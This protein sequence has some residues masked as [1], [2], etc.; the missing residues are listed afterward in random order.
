M[1]DRKKFI[2]L[3][4]A[5]IAAYLIPF[6]HPRV[7]VAILEAFFMLKEYAHEHL[8]L[9]LVPAFFIAGGITVF[10][11]QASVIKYFGAEAKKVLAYGMASVSGSILAVCSCTVLPLFTGIYQRGA[12]IGPA[13]AFLYSGP[14]INVLAIILTARVLGLK[15]GLARALGAILFS[16]V[17]GLL[18]AFIYRQQDKERLTVPG[19]ETM[20]IEKSRKLWQEL[21]YFSLM[22]AFLVFA[23]WSN[24]AEPDGLWSAIYNVKWYLSALFL[25]LLVPVLWLWFKKD[26]LKDWARETYGFALL[27]LPLLFIGVLAAGFF[28]GRPGHEAIIPSKYVE[29]VVGAEPEQ[30]FILT[31]LTIGSLHDFIEAIWSI[32]TCFFASVSGALMY[33]ATLTEIPI[34]E[35]LMGAGMGNGPAL[36]LLLAGPAVSLPN[37]LVIRGVLGTQKTLTYVALVVLMATLSGLIYGFFFD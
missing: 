12:G 22:I 37:M 8:L 23:N 21:V 6:N 4:L 35:S 26:E 1:S 29:A 16:I 30:F 25:I 17:I 36:A 31:G 13:T 18:M 15:M 14:A 20:E 11:S 24:P 5:F 2:Y 28:L 19:I 9:C 7:K 32:W 34:L 3:V 33:F 27:I 10:I